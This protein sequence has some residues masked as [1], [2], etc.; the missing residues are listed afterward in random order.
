MNVEKVERRSAF[1]CEICGTPIRIS[2]K[3]FVFSDKN[4]LKHFAFFG[5][6]GSKHF[7]F[8]YKRL[9]FVFEIK[10]LCKTNGLVTLSVGHRPTGKDGS[11]KKLLKQYLSGL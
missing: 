5:K 2:P 7:A 1:I 10:K 3:H 8:S 6:N 9:V 11:M 4:S